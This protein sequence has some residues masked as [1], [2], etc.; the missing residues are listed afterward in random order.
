MQSAHCPPSDG[1][2]PTTRRESFRIVGPMSATPI[3]MREI[4][5]TRIV[6]IILVTGVALL[7]LPY[8]TGLI[9]AAVLYVVARPLMARLDPRVAH[10][11]VAFTIVLALF[12]VIVLPSAWIFAELVAQIPDAT[13]LVSGS[14]AMERLMAMRIGDV[15]AGIMLRSASTVTAL[16]FALTTSESLRVRFHRTTEAML[17]GVVLTGVAQGTIVGGLFWIMDLPHPLLWGGVTAFASVL[18]MFGSALVWLPASLLLLAQ[19]RYVA[20]AI[21]AGIGALI[22]SNIDNALRL[23]VYHRVS[24]VHPM[25]TLVG[26]FAGVRAFGIAGVL[27]GPLVLSYMIEL[28]RLQQLPEVSVL[29]ATAA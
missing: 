7:L 16:P 24:Q 12:V 10:K 22:V 25:V 17:L 4:P 15:E 27:I 9:G 29:E 21:L 2:I 8:V 23:I 13:R 6:T 18:P 1:E 20:A 28:L 11:R 14:A 3:L 26:A 5:G 19:G